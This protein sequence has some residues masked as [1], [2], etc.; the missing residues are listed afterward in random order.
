MFGPGLIRLKAGADT[1][2]T[3][4]HDYAFISPKKNHQGNA[5]QANILLSP[6][7]KL[8]LRV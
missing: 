1:K 6:S 7:E 8:L 2:K 4:V 5:N 3:W